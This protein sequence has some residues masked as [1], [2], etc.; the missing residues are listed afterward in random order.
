[1]KSFY[2]YASTYRHSRFIYNVPHV[3]E[4]HQVDRLIIV[5]QMNYRAFLHPLIGINWNRIG[6]YYS[7][8][9]L[10]KGKTFLTEVARQI[11]I[12]LTPKSSCRSFIYQIIWYNLRLVFRWY[13]CINNLTEKFER[14]IISRCYRAPEWNRVSIQIMSS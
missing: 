5:G 8:Y 12:V 13:F 9:N 6:S 10:L 4:S 14:N 3:V 1:M 11:L 2:T 7:W